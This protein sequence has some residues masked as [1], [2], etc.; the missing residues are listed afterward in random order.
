MKRLRSNVRVQ[1]LV[2]IYVL[3]YQT[4]LFEV[5]RWL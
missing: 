1:L 3:R 2:L 4:Y 5:K